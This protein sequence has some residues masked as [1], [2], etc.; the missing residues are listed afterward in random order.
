MLRKPY[1]LESGMT[2]GLIAP[3]SA[4]G[5]DKLI[6]R[7]IGALKSRGYRVKLAR[8]ARA[9]LGFLAGTDRQRL[10]DLHSMFRNPKVD[11]I[12][13]LRGGYGTARLLKG[14]DYDLIRQNPKI[15]VGFSDITALHLA[16][17]R[18]ARLV[19][20]H[21]PMVTSNFAKKKGTLYTLEGFLRM[22]SEPEPFGSIL[23]GSGTKRGKTLRKG[24]VTAPLVGGNLSIVVTT[25][26]TPWEIS[27]KNKIV[28]LEDVGEANYRIDRMLTHLL[29]AG[30]FDGAA[31]IVF[32]KFSDCEIKP[33]G[34]G[35]ATQTIE[36]I[37]RDRM[38]HLKIPIA[39]DFPFGH[40]DYTATLPLGI[41]ATLNATKGDLIIEESAVR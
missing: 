41:K 30:K 3:A 13:C 21:G 18:K 20:F 19:T 36:E 22:L 8:C 29:N 14:I 37:L 28:F 7:G 16:F 17:L 25:L 40:V 10:A 34:D 2:I 12:F 24:Q 26:G 39:Y 15:F 4:P 23:P 9:K 11:A 38:G 5:D 1:R 33:T 6:D 31:G 27:T 35:C 32:G